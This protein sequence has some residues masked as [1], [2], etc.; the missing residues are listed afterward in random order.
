MVGQLDC[1]VLISACGIV[2]MFLLDVD[3]NKAL[4]CSTMPSYLIL[5]SVYI[6]CMIFMV[7]LG[8]PY[9]SVS[10]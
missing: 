6:F 10:S 7:S 5:I 1:I 9:F 8:I 4:A 2:S 3:L